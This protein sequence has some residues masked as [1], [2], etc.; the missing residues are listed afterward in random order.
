MIH[1]VVLTDHLENELTWNWTALNSWSSW[2]WR[3]NSCPPP[4]PDH[5]PGWRKRFLLIKKK[6][7]N[8]SQNPVRWCVIC[9]TTPKTPVRSGVIC[10]HPPKTPVRSG[11]ICPLLDRDR[12]RDRSVDEPVENWKMEIQSMSL[13]VGKRVSPLS[14][15]DMFLL[16]NEEVKTPPREGN[17]EIR[18][19][20]VTNLLNT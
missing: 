6:V 9:W 7:R 16:F 19:K 8:R 10:F 11:L 13:D 12:V 2:L 1:G 18:I 3:R 4:S 5:H 14:L 17:T 15:S 20:R